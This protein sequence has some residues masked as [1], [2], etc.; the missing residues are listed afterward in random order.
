MSSTYTI[1]DL[2]TLQWPGD[3]KCLDYIFQ[4]DHTLENIAPDDRPS[5]KMIQEMFADS[6]ESGLGVR[7][8]IA[9]V[10]T[11]RSAQPTGS[12]LAYVCFSRKY[13][14]VRLGGRDTALSLS[15]VSRSLGHSAS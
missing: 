14:I 3:K 1:Q 7:A 12:S 4:F 6:C 5:D 8:R 11:H 9:H 13:S 10:F 15:L 2:M